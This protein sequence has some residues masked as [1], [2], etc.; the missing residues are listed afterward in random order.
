MALSLFNLINTLQQ[1]HGANDAQTVFDVGANKG[2]SYK[3]F[4]L[5]LPNARIFCFEPAPETF[6]S[7]EETVNNDPLATTHCFALAAQPATFAFTTGLDSGNRIVEKDVS[8]LQNTI[9]VEAIRGDDFCRQNQIE[10][11]DFLKIDTEG[12]DLDVLVG[13]SELLR[14]KRILA[15]Q[16]ECGTSLD[17]RFHV[18]LERFIH[19]LHPYNYRLHSIVDPVR[20]IHKTRQKLQGIWYCNAVFVLE[21][22]SPKLRRDG[23]N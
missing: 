4:R 6:K 15:V 16:V 13:F 1:D 7:L 19:F 23:N 22:G 14:E 18:H 17:N 21:V 11:V 3:D 10:R 8:N 9:E 20:K 2:Q 5:A 12:Y